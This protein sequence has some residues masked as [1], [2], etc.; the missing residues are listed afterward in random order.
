MIMRATSSWMTIA[1]V[2][3]LL[4]TG[5]S[6]ASGFPNDRAA[7]GPTGEARIAPQGPTQPGMRTGDRDP[8]IDNEGTDDGTT[9]TN[10]LTPVTYQ[11]HAAQITD[12]MSH[13][14][15]D[16][17]NQNWLES[18]TLPPPD[19]GDFVHGNSL[20]P[21]VQNYRL[22]ADT[23]GCA[24]N[25]NQYWYA[26]DGPIAPG[27]P[28][29]VQGLNSSRL[30][31][32]E[33]L[34]K[35]TQTWANAALAWRQ[36]VEVHTCLVT[37]LNAYGHYV[38][39]WLGGNNVATKQGAAGLGIQFNSASTYS[40][41]EALWLALPS[42]ATG[43]PQTEKTGGGVIASAVRP[44][45]KPPRT[46]SA[47]QLYAWPLKGLEHSCGSHTI[48]AVNWRVCGKLGVGAK[49]EQINECDVT[50]TM[51]KNWDTCEKADG[52]VDPKLCPCVR[53]ARGS[54]TCTIAGGRSYPVLETRLRP[55]D[56]HLIYGGHAPS[57]SVCSA[58]PISHTTPKLTGP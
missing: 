5:C 47:V 58:P 56:W 32:G 6:G 25:A 15:I 23:I 30:F 8:P 11:D 18:L 54:W 9:T 55:Q 49:P 42:S 19:S 21:A 13:P 26:G 37:R 57:S 22:L 45:V 36:A 31:K 39:I 48:D 51:V 43:T 3:L 20:D 29:N 14:L 44:A 28:S 33:G 53:S 4:T 27:I 40:Y 50:V 38:P 17:G 7:R 52:N 24:L 10:G 41:E 46:G 35:A 16:V 2:V 1:G 12:L 34:M